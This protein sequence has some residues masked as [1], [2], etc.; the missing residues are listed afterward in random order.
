MQAALL[1]V[2]ISI[3]AGDVV[4]SVDYALRHGAN[5]VIVVKRS[6]GTFKSTKWDGQ[7]GK[8]HSLFDSRKGKLVYIF[9]NSVPARPRMEISETGSLSLQDSIENYMSS[10]QL[11]ELNLKPGYNRGSYVAPSLE[12]E[13]EFNVFLYTDQDK[14]VLSDIDGTITESDIQGHV[15]PRFGITAEHDKVVELFD[16]IADRG[17]HLVYLTARSQSQEEE[18]KE[19]LFEMLQNRA[20]YSIPPGP[21]LFSPSTFIS[22]LV[23]E[24]VDGNPYVQKTQTI[25][26][27]WRSF[28]T[29]DKSGIMHTV[30]TAYG[31][32]ETDVTAYVDAGIDPHSIYIVNPQAELV[33]I[34]SGEVSSY[35]HQ[36]ETIE[37]L[38]PAI[39]T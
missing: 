27:I 15:L 20:G 11:A 6:D 26:D 35:A 1:W 18:T 21:V 19:Y 5:D 2:L 10:K 7:F 9:V 13:I 30:M 25:A 8:L 28:N 14:L 22:S 37:L 32:K 17:Y 31:N 23:T 12:E 16:K 29:P 39:R 24:V 33:N 38:Y 4:H 3:L 34:G 36:A